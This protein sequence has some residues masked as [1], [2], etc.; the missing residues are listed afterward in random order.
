MTQS[1]STHP[2]PVLEAEQGL[3][4]FSH[5]LQP[6]IGRASPCWSTGG[7]CL[8]QVRSAHG[9]EDET[10]G[11]DCSGTI[12]TGS[13][14]HSGY[15]AIPEEN[16]IFNQPRELLQ[17]LYC[18]AGACYAQGL[19]QTPLGRGEQPGGTLPQCHATAEPHM[20]LPLR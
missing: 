4:S 16:Q 14:S 10:T 7:S 18:W 11:M 12:S 19:K 15:S 5:R 3:S 2:V 20:H 6:A 1:C 13:S 9:R 17:A 8:H